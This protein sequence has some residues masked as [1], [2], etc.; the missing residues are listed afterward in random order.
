[1]L[2]SNY[3]FLYYFI[4]NQFNPSGFANSNQSPQWPLPNANLEGDTGNFNMMIDN[5]AAQL[6][7][8]AAVVTAPNYHQK[9][10]DRMRD[11]E[12]KCNM[13]FY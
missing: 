7:V 8:V 6:P 5:N 2:S 4:R 1:M 12:S 13:N 3:V 9:T 10:S 11:D